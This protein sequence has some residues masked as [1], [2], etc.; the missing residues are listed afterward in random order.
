MCRKGRVLGVLGLLGFEAWQT[1]G[2]KAL[3]REGY[4]QAKEGFRH[5]RGFTGLKPGKRQARRP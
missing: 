5:F 3:T 4:V 1:A 2:S